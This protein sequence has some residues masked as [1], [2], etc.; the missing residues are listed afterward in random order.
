MNG[1][2]M[3][4]AQAAQAEA[5]AAKAVQVARAVEQQVM[6]WQAVVGWLMRKHGETSILVP[7][8]EHREVVET[9]GIKVSFVEA[10]P[11]AGGPAERAMVVDLLTRADLEAKAAEA[12]AQRP[13][14][15]IAR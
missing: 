2:D 9:S 4:R 10:Q 3:L 11:D 1:A 13:V 7:A 14:L 8:S 5:R 6:Y 12:E 15:R